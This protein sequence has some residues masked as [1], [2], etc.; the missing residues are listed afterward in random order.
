MQWAQRCKRKR[1]RVKEIKWSKKLQGK[2]VDVNRWEKD[3]D[4]TR[5]HHRNLL[6]HLQKDKRKNR[7][8]KPWRQ[9][10]IAGM[11]SHRPGPKE[12]RQTSKGPP[13]SGSPRKI[14]VELDH[15]IQE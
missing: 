12:L 5:K 10:T 1:Q 4:N 11:R 15:N 6:L 3:Q 9:T 7:I 2:E 8:K 14:T 13:E